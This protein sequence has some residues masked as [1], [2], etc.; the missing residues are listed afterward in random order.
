MQGVTLNTGSDL[1]GDKHNL[2]Y[3]DIT[4]AAVTITNVTVTLHFK[5]LF[6]GNATNAV[7]MVP[8]KT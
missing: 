1:I 5:F 4:N 6:T 3:N 7:L 2:T 8:H